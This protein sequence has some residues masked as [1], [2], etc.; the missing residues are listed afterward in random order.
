[1]IARLIS[2]SARN[3]VLVLVGT[4][5]AAALGLWALLH[6]PLDALPD[7]S[8]TQVIVYTEFPGQAPQVIEDQVTYPLA[9][10][11]LTVPSARV[12]RGFSFFGASYVYVIFEDGTDLY[13]ARSRV[14]EYLNNVSRRL[15]PGAVPTLGPDATGIGWVYQYAVLAKDLSLAETRSL[16]DWRLRYGLARAG[17]VAEVAPVGGFVRQYNVVV[18]PLRLRA[19]GIPLEQVRQAVRDSNM[20]V[21]GRTVE[22]SDFEFMVRGRGYLRGTADLEQVVL[23]SEGGTPVR[24][25]DVARVELGPDE[26]R[27]IAELNGEGEVTSAIVL[28]RVGANA[29]DVIRNAKAR[30]AELLPSLPEGTEIVPVYDRSGLIEAAIETLK[31]TLLEESL[32]VAA[33]TVLFLLHLR[34]ALVAILMLP[35]GVLMAFAAMR[36]LG[37]GSNIMS[38]G[39]IAIAVGAMVDAAIVMIESVHKHLERAPAGRPRLDVMVEAMAEVGPALFFSLLVITV[40]FVPIFA[41]EAQEGRLFHPLA[42]TKSFAMAASALL[43]V[44]LVPA[45]MVLFVRG[46]IVPEHRNPVN[47]LLIWLYRPVI[48]GV[49]RARILTVLLALAAL[50]ATAW[51]AARLGGEFMPALDEGT[52]LYMPTTL[53]GLSV[54]RAGELLQMQDR[55]IRTFPEVVSVY[56]KAG[57][58][59]TA[60]DPAPIEMFETV[61]RLRPKAEWRPG[62][63]TDALIAEMDRALQFP[64]VSNAWTMPIR[65]RIDMLST[66]IRT[67]VGVKVFG[68]DLAEIERLAR[69]VEA[70]VR[71]VPGTTSAYAERIIGGYYLDVV[72]DRAAL[73]RYGLSV[74]DVQA[75][76][77]MALGGETVT[78]TVEGR[79]RYGVNLR[80]PRELRDDPQAIAAEVQVPLPGGAGGSVPLGEVT[81][82]GLS[83]G[84][85]AIRTEGGEPV[86]YVFVDLRGRDLRGFVE[87]AR[88]AVA[89]EVAF[90][91][92][93]RAVWSGQF[94]YLERAEA[95]LRVVVPAT[96]L[97]IFLLLYLNFRSVTETLIVMLSLPFALVGGVWLVWWMGFNLSVAV[98]VGFIAL[99]GVA[100]ETGVVMLIFLDHALAAA[101][102]RC[103]EEGRVFGRA[104]LHAAILEGAVDRV[105]PKMMTVVAIMAGLMPILWSTGTGSEVMRRIAMPMVGGMV[106]STLLTLLVIPAVYGLAKGWGLPRAAGRIQSSAHI[107]D[108]AV[109]AGRSIDQQRKRAAA[110][111]AGWA[112]PPRRLAD[113]GAEGGTG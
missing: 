96:V 76:V 39:G 59:A 15:P 13:W 102:A 24:L 85:T 61:I 37:I 69:Q 92:G 87:E 36:W 33:V 2:W 43:S 3:V 62:L 18:D 10:A 6:T 41:L 109:L 81:R 100:A 19:L 105:R 4:A 67:P 57:R 90:P 31:H 65:A 112:A 108:Q 28:Q 51:P 52:L 104:D 86:G 7:L 55:I 71:A 110:D 106:S 95:R 50:G 70:V 80:Y 32:V 40:S 11:M 73:G 12:V 88:R 44:T 64:G 17:G 16:Q 29:L 25:S 84:A 75:A 27:G 98:A 79:E 66:G 21:G 23:R 83:R 111:T 34:S 47:R 107:S 91:P 46:R 9:S 22:L 54:T 42:Y 5:F 60:T 14:L 68:P 77:A 20:D 78:T 93:Y 113:S 63:T 45:L 99:A 38:L 30:L 49:L 35:V 53:P 58:A 74:A 26:R 56:G 101:R 8:D 1:M 82:V 97:V 103:L 94:E 48:R 72:P 89:A